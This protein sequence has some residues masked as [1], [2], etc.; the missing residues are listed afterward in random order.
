[1][2]SSSSGSTPPPDLRELTLKL[3]Q[4]SDYPLMDEFAQAT[5]ADS[6][7]TSF[8]LP[9]VCQHFQRKQRRLRLIQTIQQ[10]YRQSQP[11]EALIEIASW[12]APG[13][14]Y[15]HFDGLM[16]EAFKSV[17]R[18][19]RLVPSLEPPV[20]VPEGSAALLIHVRGSVT[21]ERSLILTEE[22]HDR[23]WDAVSRLPS[24]IVELSRGQAGRSVL[25]LGVSPRDPL[26]RRLSKQLLETGEARIQGPTYF[27]CVDHTAVD[28]AYWDKYDVQWLP[29]TV[30]EVVASVS[31]GLSRTV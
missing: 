26:V 24:R 4:E 22:D 27:A 8:I 7:M 14:I 19:P 1:M 6:W 11:H 2:R 29:H 17:R 30:Q 9:S 25:F 12:D 23:L 28:D 3:A 18:V 16:D 15:T 13:I 20:D 31:R 21:N 10:A 5:R